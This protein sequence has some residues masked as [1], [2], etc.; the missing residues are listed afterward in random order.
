[1]LHL[2][3]CHG[4]IMPRL[5]E[6]LLFIYLFYFIYLF[7]FFFFLFV[8]FF[9]FFFFLQT[10]CTD[11]HMSSPSGTE[12]KLYLIFVLHILEYVG[13]PQLPSFMRIHDAYIDVQKEKIEIQKDI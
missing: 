10:A 3:T 8:F 9:F 6:L 13:L 4:R 2:I 11:K 1:M 12:R 7:I 5:A